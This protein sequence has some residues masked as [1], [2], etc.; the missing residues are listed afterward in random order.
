MNWERFYANYPRQFGRTDYLSQVGHTHDGRP[1]PKEH[2]E[3]IVEGISRTLDLA[4]TDSV[5]DLCCGNGLITHQIAQRVDRV[6]G[7]DFSRT[8]LDIAE[9]DHRQRNVSYQQCNVLEMSP[10]ILGT[11]TFDKV[12]MYGALQHFTSGQLTALLESILRHARPRRIILLGFIPDSEKKWTLYDSPQKR[13]AHILRLARRRERMGTWWSP[14][15]ISE[16]ADRLGLTCAKLAVDSALDASRYR[17]DVRL[18]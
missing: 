5:L 13:M 18:T 15:F 11:E 10:E 16:C 14:D 3:T 1:I 4:P 7:V 17:F 8:L 12:L 9:S 2:F 6:V